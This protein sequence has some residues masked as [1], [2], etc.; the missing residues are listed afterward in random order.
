MKI[1]LVV[2]GSPYAEMATKMLKA[3]KLRSQTEVT[4][5]T[6]VP[7][8]TFLGGL[9]LDTVRGKA[10]SKKEI[11]ETQQQRAIELVQGAANVLSAGKLKVES[12]VRW[13]NPAEEILK[14]AHES[15][16]SL[17]VM[18]AKG[19]TDSAQ[20]LLGSVAHKV[21]RHARASVL[22]ARKETTTISRVLLA[23][24]GSK[25]SEMAANFLLNLPLPRRSQVIMV[26]T[27]LSHIV[28]LVKTPTLDLQT[29]QQLIT[30][31]QA[32]EEREA[33][34]IIARTEN[35]FSREGYKTLSLVMLGGA[36][37]S[38]LRVA[39]EYE[40]D[41]VVLGAKGLSGIESFL[42]GS[43][44]ERVARYAKCLVLIGRVLTE[45]ENKR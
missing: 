22:L 12:L 37:E 40:T 44:A 24:D 36:A 41:I 21:M 8:H 1:L 23:T 43:V 27:V 33:R 3:F 32:C 7:E 28:A 45:T 14:M 38:I 17:V 11:H 13:G 31:L 30:E 19:L 35:Q 26:T 20:F 25:Y 15:G 5:M 34:N 42:L 9:T 39:Q 16:I 2:D 29:N 6:V 4:V 10:P 18:G